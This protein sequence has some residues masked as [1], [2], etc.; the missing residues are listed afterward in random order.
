M[1]K[2]IA[3]IFIIILLFGIALAKINYPKPL[4]Y[5]KVVVVTEKKYDLE[6]EIIKSGNDYYYMLGNKADKILKNIDISQIKGI[7]FYL[8]GEYKL[9]D[10]KKHFNYMVFDSKSVQNK[11]VYYGYDD[12]YY[13]FKIIDGKKINFQLV[14][15]QN[16]WI[17]GY[18]MILTGF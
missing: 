1:K 2:M 15:D 11:K 4:N 18:P 5:E 14:E 6:C 12:S 3:F 13:N 17:L 9:Q 7:V 10:L 8:P 16:Q